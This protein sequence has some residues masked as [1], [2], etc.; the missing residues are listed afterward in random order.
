MQVCFPTNMIVKILVD[1]SLVDS[2]ANSTTQKHTSPGDLIQKEAL[3]TCNIP[4][5]PVAYIQF[6]TFSFMAYAILE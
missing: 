5:T 2:S 3:T 4:G 6:T 1:L